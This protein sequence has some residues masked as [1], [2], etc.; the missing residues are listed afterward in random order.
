MSWLLPC[1]S[2]AG[3]RW[4]QKPIHAPKTRTIANLSRMSCQW[5]WASSA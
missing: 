2:D 5:T 1:L 4:F 3:W